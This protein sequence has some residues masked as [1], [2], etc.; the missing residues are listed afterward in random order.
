MIG[1]ASPGQ[2]HRLAPMR[3]LTSLIALV[4]ALGLVACGGSDTSSSTSTG[5]SG[6]SG[7]QG[8]I[9]ASEMTAAEFVD[10]SIPDEINAVK[11][12]VQDNPDCAGADASAGSHFQVSVSVNA[13]T[14]APDTPLTD[15]VAQTCNE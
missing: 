3:Y 8:P 5:A 11:Q 9:S 10:A 12:A 15:V 6:A 4:A 2:T 14:A 7:A 13:A 1:V